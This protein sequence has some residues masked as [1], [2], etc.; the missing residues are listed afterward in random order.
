MLISNQ[1]LGVTAEDTVENRTVTNQND[2]LNKFLAN[3][4]TSNSGCIAL[5]S[6][7]SQTKKLQNKTFSQN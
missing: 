1:Q 7:L 2:I 4:K 3:V 6:S 5:K